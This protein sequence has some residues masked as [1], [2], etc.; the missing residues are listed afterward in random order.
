MDALTPE[1]GALAV[2]LARSVLEHAIG[3]KPEA[4]FDLPPVFREKRGVFVTL[5][6]QGELR[7]CIGFPYPHLALEKAV[8]EAA[9]AAARED[10]RFSPVGKAEL[11]RIRVEV[12]V[13]TVPML[14]EAEPL[15]RPRAVQVGRHGLIVRGFGR[16]G[17]LLPQVPVEWR[18]DSREF[19]DHTCMKAGLPGGCWMQREV[20][21][22]TFEG[23]IFHEPPQDG[24]GR[25]G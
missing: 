12:T 14:L 15:D 19:L 22:Y 18:W 17:L 20:E 6:S 23:Q 2:R 10:P 8:R 4:V 3:G 13:L 21:V 5:T 16:S 11:A 9:Y 25:E 7:G 1:E 24:A